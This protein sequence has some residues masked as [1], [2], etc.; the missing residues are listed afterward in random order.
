MDKAKFLV[1]LGDLH[2]GEQISKH[3]PRIE[4][5]LQHMMDFTSFMPNKFLSMHRDQ[6]IYYKIMTVN[7]HTLRDKYKKKNNL[8]LK[9]CNSG[10]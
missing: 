5:A 7:K 8:K 6:D 1:T 10:T 4:H 3:N 2:Q 9:K